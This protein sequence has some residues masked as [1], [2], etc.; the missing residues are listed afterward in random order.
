MSTPSAFVFDAYGTLFDVHSIAGL[1]EEVAPR[2]GGILSQLWRTKQLEYSWL[3]SLMLSPSQP[4]DDF[5]A[6]TAHALDYALSQ[7]T[8]A[9]DAADRARLLDG[10]R[11]LAPYPDAA[12]ALAALAPRPRWILSNGTKA[13]LDPLIAGSALAPQL[14]GVLSVDAAGIYKPSP[15]VYQLA[16]D[17]LGLAP[18]DIGFVSSNGWD[19]TGAKAFGFTTFWINR[20]GLPV[21]RH[22]PPPDYVLGSL[23]EFAAL[24]L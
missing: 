8:I 19:A 24:G 7:L 1:A 23:S 20:L 9:L 5:S 15:R 14:D 22:G 12:A 10:Y 11:D 18:A 21:E 16:V 2:Q 6:L 4:R 13:M 3:Q 17:R